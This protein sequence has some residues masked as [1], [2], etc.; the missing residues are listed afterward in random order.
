[1][2]WVLFAIFSAII[3]TVS[4]SIRKNLLKKHTVSQLMVFVYL[5]MMISSMCLSLML[6]P[7]DLS[8]YDT[9]T[10]ILAV[11]AGLLIPIVTYTFTKSF[12]L[13]SNMEYPVVVFAV[14]KTLLLLLVSIYI[15]Q[16]PANKMAIFGIFLALVGVSIVV[17]S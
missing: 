10:I 6:K 5:G 11:V 2:L 17:L 7:N 12:N 16:I 15:F 3:I 8:G 14:V 4:I 13:V 9:K 1:M